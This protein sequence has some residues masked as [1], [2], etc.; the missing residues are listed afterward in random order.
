MEILPCRG[1]CGY[2]VTHFWRQA[3]NAIFFQAKGTHD[4]PQPEAK[5]SSE[6]RRAL[7]GGRRI[8]SL[9]VMLARDAALNNKLCTLRGT[10]RNANSIPKTD[11][12]TFITPIHKKK[13]ICTE[14]NCSCPSH[15]N[16]YVGYPTEM[17]FYAWNPS[18]NY[19][20]ATGHHTG[21]QIF[22]GYDEHFSN[23]TPNNVQGIQYVNPANTGFSSM[24]N[25]YFHPNDVQT[26]VKP[27]GP[28]LPSC[29]SEIESNNAQNSKWFPEH[30]K[31][32]S[33]D[34]TSS[35][36]SSSSIYEEF[37]YAPIQPNHGTGQSNHVQHY[38]PNNCNYESLG[39]YFEQ[40]DGSCVYST[41]NSYENST[42][43]SNHSAPAASPHNTEA[44][45]N[46]SN[47]EHLEMYNGAQFQI[48]GSAS[49]DFY[50]S[51]SGKDVW[52]I[53]VDAQA[54]QPTFQIPSSESVANV[55]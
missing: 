13:C 3:G 46:Y 32:E 53:S 31:Y 41:V 17:G 21:E 45:Q 18:E 20:Y 48:N 14:S 47:S 30:C 12:S 4:H 42:P 50:Y 1:H 35:L 5:G 23:G 19:L 10:K 25:T 7:G 54:Y 28:S 2:P 16:N 11:D 55:Y 40:T 43:A 26:D 39:T 36:T 34:D 24:Q 8:R 52:N 51:N 38:A 15:N 6:A 49:P 29:I 37:Y 33:C 22:P 44:V 27:T 9:A